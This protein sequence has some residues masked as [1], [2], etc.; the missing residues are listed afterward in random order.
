MN[1]CINSICLRE[2]IR[3]IINRNPSQ[4]AREFKEA[5]GEVDCR[6]VDAIWKES[7]WREVLILLEEVLKRKGQDTQDD[8]VKVGKSSFCKFHGKICRGTRYLH[9]VNT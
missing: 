2:E 9:Y 1:F 5:S 4:W 8:W 7:E 6:I 3:G